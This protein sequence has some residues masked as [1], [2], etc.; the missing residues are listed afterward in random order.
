VIDIET[1]KSKLIIMYSAYSVAMVHSI[2]RLMKIK[3][4]ME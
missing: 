4:N 1:L 3:I 2:H